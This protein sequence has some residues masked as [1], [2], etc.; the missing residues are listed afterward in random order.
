MFLEERKKFLE[1]YKNQKNLLFL[2]L[3]MLSDNQ[4][5]PGALHTAASATML[6]V[7]VP[8]L[9]L[10]EYYCSIQLYFFEQELQVSKEVFKMLNR[11]TFCKTYEYY[12]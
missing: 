4:M 10:M 2:E 9:V 6:L 7:T 8:L 1:E 3:A 11:Q 12:Q 5:F